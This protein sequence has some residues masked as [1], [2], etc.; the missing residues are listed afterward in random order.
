MQISSHLPL[1][2]Y[3][4]FHCGG[5][6]EHAIVIDDLGQLDTALAST[7]K[8]DWVMGY[9]SNSVV[10]DA[11]LPGTTLLFRSGSI[12]EQDGLLIADAG[13]WWDDLVVYAI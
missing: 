1:A 13:V 2:P 10:S 12:E 3:T 8:I 11:G 9:G 6:A 4:S 7:S 5:E